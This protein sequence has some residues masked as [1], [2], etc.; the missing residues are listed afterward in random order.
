MPILT[1]LTAEQ[2]LRYETRRGPVDMRQELVRGAIVEMTPP[3]A[4]HGAAQ[5]GIGSLLQHAAEEA[6]TGRVFTETGFVLMRDPDTVR[7]PDV[8]FVRAARLLG[9][10]PDGFVEGPPDLAV[11]IRSPSDGRRRVEDALAD[12][13]AAKTPVVWLVDPRARTLT[14]FTRGREPVVLGEGDEVS[15]VPLA[16]A[17]RLRVAKLLGD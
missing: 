7:A 14:V 1:Q 13:R 2:F 17:R 12:Y 9:G 10:I 16:P 8:A 6:G 11:E 15:L 3:G 4:R 5:V